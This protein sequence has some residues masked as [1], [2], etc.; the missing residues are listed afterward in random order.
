MFI[1]IKL[2][3]VRRHCLLTHYFFDTPKSKFDTIHIDMPIELEKGRN[4]PLEFLIIRRK[5]LKNKLKEFEYLQNMVHNSNTKNYRPKDLENRNGYLIMSEHDEI[6]NQL[7][8]S[9]VGQLLLNGKDFLE[10]LHVT[11]QKTYNNLALMMKATL[12]IPPDA[13]ENEHFH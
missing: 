9:K 11:D 3:L 5:D 1:E 2:S 4:L 13:S 8:D 12:R 7:I 10:E 6:A